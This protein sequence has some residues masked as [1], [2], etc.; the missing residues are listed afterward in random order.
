VIDLN[1]RRLGKY[2]LDRPIGRGGMASV[3]LAHD[4]GLNRPVAV[5]VMDPASTAEPDAVERFRRE[6]ILAANLE[7]PNIV[8]VYDVAESD[9]LWY[10]AMRFV[11]GETVREILAR[12]APLR[13]D[14]IVRILRPVASALDYAH[15]NGVIHRDVK[16]GNILV[17]PNGSVVLTDFGIARM[18][19]DARL[20]RAGQVMGTADYLAPE[21][22]RGE[23]ATA[24]SDIYSLGILL[25]EMIT[26]RPPFAGETT[27]EVLYKQVNDPPPRLRDAGVDAP[28]GLQAVLDRALNKTPALRYGSAAELAQAVAGIAE[29]VD[30]RAPAAPARSAA[31]STPA[32][33]PAEPA[34][35]TPGASQPPAPTARRRLPAA[36]LAAVALI[37]LLAV[38]ALAFAAMRNAPGG[39]PVPT[40]G[41]AFAAPAAVTYTGPRRTGNGDDLHANR[42]LRAPTIDGNLDDWAGAASWP[43]RYPA[44]G[45]R[46]PTSTADLSATFAFAYD[47]AN[48]YASAV[49][50]DNVHVQTARTRGLELWKG[51]DVELW[52]DTNLAGD[53][54]VDPANAGALKDDWQIGLSPGDFAALA[55]ESIFFVP[56]GVDSAKLGVR[57]AA[58]PRPGLEGYTLEVAV[59]WSAL[60]TRPE[61]GGAIGFCA[62]AGDNDVA[63]TPQ[64]QHMVTT[65][66]RMKWNTPTT[67]GNLFW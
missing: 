8:P 60:Q 37:L 3:Y 65:C 29:R 53:F 49:I 63:A 24:A 46:P 14:R 33:A 12:E 44:P 67:F 13:L 57:V 55:P 16:P 28:P 26:G 43:A 31:R 11:P 62:S 27:A 40:L 25:Y 21:Q 64:Q 59:P 6:A 54:A 22:I 19:A 20:T 66:R 2:I 7:H 17:E 35:W 56:K 34:G 5:K 45:L 23:T 42:A 51:D 38:G 39:L 1:G 52:L 9:G 4:P 30:G 15:A 48:F 61:A 18:G 41:P 36:P 50:T 10:L 58:A 32:P 47:D